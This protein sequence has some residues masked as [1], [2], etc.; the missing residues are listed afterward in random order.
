[1]YLSNYAENK[2]LDHVLKNS[3]YTR[4]AALF[5]ALATATIVDT[6]RGATISEMSGGSYARVSCDSWTAASGRATNN[7]AKLSFPTPS[8]DWGLGLNFAIL[9]TS[10]LSTGNIIAYGEI[11]PPNLIDDTDSVDIEV[12]QLD[13]S[14]NKSGSSDY[15]AN[16]LLDHLF[17]DSA[18]SQPT[19]IYVGLSTVAIVDGNTGSTISEPS[20]GYARIN[21]NGWDVAVLGASQNTNKIQFAVASGTWGD[22]GYFGLSDHLSTGNILIHGSFAATINVIAGN[23]FKITIGNVSATF[24]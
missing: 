6:D 11:G 5:I 9:D 8:A 22:V 4:P 20:D 21:D 23:K 19:N 16:A 7:S 13:V 17:A 3:A 2:L 15:L 12:G 24:N 1:M 18:Y 14:F 10:V